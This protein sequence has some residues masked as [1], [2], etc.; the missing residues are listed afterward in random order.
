MFNYEM[1]VR[2]GLEPI[3][4]SADTERGRLLVEWAASDE[5]TR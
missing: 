4:A 1:I 3:F 2:G 5:R